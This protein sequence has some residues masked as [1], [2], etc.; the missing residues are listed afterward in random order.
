VRGDDTA[1]AGRGVSPMRVLT[2]C[3]VL[4]CG[5][6]PPDLQQQCERIVDA[7]LATL[8]Q[9]LV[10]KCKLQSAAVQAAIDQAVDDKL[11]SLGCVRSDGGDEWT[12][13][14]ASICR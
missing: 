10:D 3:A 13:A 14:G 5:C 4:A 6:V 1:R 2:L 11:T 9:D 7:K 12:C 8:E